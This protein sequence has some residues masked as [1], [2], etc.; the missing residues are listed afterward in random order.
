MLGAILLVVMPATLAGRPKCLKSEERRGPM[1]VLVEARMKRMQVKTRAD[2]MR[3]RGR[4]R[5]V[6]DDA[7]VAGNGTDVL[8]KESC[9]AIGKGRCEWCTGEREV[10]CE[11]KTGARWT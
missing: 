6:A 4:S 5:E 3:V 10:V 1:R 8:V 11:T 9:M 7:S 2:Q